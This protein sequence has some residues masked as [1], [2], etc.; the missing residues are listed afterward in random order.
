MHD[1]DIVRPREPWAV[2]FSV[3]AVFAGCLI[4]GFV[5]MVLTYAMLSTVPADVLETAGVDTNVARLTLMVGGIAGVLFLIVG[6]TVAFGL[7]WLLRNQR[8]QS[9]HVLVFAIAGAAVGALSGF[10]GGPEMGS[11]VAAMT[12]TSA[13]VSR[14]IMSRWART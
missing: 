9:V 1:P 10:W 5:F 4:A 3:G 8:N 6:P 13:G 11:M 7:G 2:G 14:M 12:G